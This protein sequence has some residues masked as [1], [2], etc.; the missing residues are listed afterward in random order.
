[1]GYDPR[2]SQKCE[3]F[4]T[5]EEEDVMRALSDYTMDP[6]KG[7]STDDFVSIDALY[8]RYLDYMRFY[9]N[10]PDSGEPMDRR[11]FG[12]ALRRVFPELEDNDPDARHP[13]SS[14]KVRRMYDGRRRW[15]YFHMLGPESVKSRD[16]PGPVPKAE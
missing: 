3:D 2:R 11:C 6:A 13:Q 9:C 14:Y 5:E 7:A 12:A 10:D 1:M 16:E 8:Q 4:L 15:G